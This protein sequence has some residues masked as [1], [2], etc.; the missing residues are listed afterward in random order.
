M[1][2]LQMIELLH[3]SDAIARF[4]PNKVD[5]STRNGEEAISFGLEALR[6]SREGFPVAGTLQEMLQRTAIECKI[7]LP[8]SLKDL[9]SAKKAY[10]LDDFIE[11]CTRPSYKQPVKDIQSRFRH[12]FSEDWYNDGPKYGFKDIDPL[13]SRTRV[14]QSEEEMGAQNLMHIRNLLN[15]I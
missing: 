6:E 9:V 7:P 2:T 4:F 15:E 1:S 10:V 3:F 13:E 11:A 12:D 14:T 8:K 5:S